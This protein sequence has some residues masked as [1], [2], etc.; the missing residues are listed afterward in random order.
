[1]LESLFKKVAGLQTA[2]SIFLG[3]MLS[4]F[5]FSTFI[6]ENIYE[7]WIKQW[8]LKVDVRELT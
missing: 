3:T 8:F 2:A 7:R 4:S 5:L 1:M 6:R